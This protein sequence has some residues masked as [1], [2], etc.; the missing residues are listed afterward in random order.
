MSKLIS[1]A[2]KTKVCLIFKKNIVQKNSV[3]IFLPY[4]SSKSILRLN[5]KILYSFNG[6][7]SDKKVTTKIKK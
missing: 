3:A 1:I 5:K 7:P 2:I 6:I 4:G